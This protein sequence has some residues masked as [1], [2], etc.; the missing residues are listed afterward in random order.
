MNPLISIFFIASAFFS[1]NTITQSF[2]GNTVENKNQILASLLFAVP[3]YY[4]LAWRK[5]KK[6]NTNNA[7]G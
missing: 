7:A 2:L 6:N 4:F 3:M 1:L 5:A